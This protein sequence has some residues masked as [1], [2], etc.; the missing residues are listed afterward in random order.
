MIT[1]KDFEKIEMRTGTIT[2]VANF[3]DAKKPA[4]QLTIDFGESGIK[5]SSAQITQLYTREALIGK[6]V[7]AVVNLP[8]KQIGK[9]FSECLVMGVYN[10]QNDVVL[11]QP[12]LPVTNG[13]RIG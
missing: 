2:A 5:K 4:Y 10:L 8:T 9:F 11:L 3:P 12:S 6:Q 13:C 7:V 1:W